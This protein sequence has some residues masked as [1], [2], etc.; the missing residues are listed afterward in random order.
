ME[1]I[2][3]ER[4]K[5]I[6]DMN[7][8]PALWR[9][10]EEISRSLP[11]FYWLYG[12]PGIGDCTVFKLF[13]RTGSPE[14]IYYA[15]ENTLKSWQEERLL[16]PAQLNNLIKS[17]KEANLYTVYDKLI[18]NQIK[19]IPFYH[20]NFPEKLKNIPDPPCVLFV[21]GCLP[22]PARKSLAIIG[23]RNCSAYGERMAKEFAEIIGGAGVQIIS[24]MAVGVDGISQ[25]AAL[26]SGGTSYGVLGCGVDIC[27]PARNRELYRRLI[28]KGGVISTYLPGTAP[29]SRYFPP[30]NRIISG[31]SDGVLVIEAR[32]KSGTLITVDMA[33][34]QG[35]EV[36]AL[37]GRVGDAISEGCNALIASGAGIA[38]SP[39]KLLYELTGMEAGEK[40]N[41]IDRGVMLTD[42]EQLVYDALDDYPQALDV[43]HNELLTKS[44]E[45]MDVGELL[46]ILIQLCIKGCADQLGGG[47]VYARR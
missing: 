32:E 43:I 13:E 45:K 20:P 24:G 5:T 17:K 6:N 21:K 12:I 47:M 1:N 28:E 23:A 19:I 16:S 2:T 46:Q 9:M 36:Y 31:L 38:L 27:Y 33:L 41:G 29:Q 10:K 8:N 18:Q 35:K 44:G 25:W 26:K 14:E 3:N 40:V 39:E 30:R 4:R 22:N 34:E 7:I 15:T 37:P 11:Y 42:R